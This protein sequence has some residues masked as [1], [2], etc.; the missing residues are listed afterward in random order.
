[1]WGRDVRVLRGVGRVRRRAY[2]RGYRTVGEGSTG[3]CCQCCPSAG[4]AEG[5]AT[6]TTQQAVLRV[7]PEKPSESSVSEFDSPYV[8][9]SRA[10]FDVYLEKKEELDGCFARVNAQIQ[11]L[12]DLSNKEQWSADAGQAIL[13]SFRRNC[14]LLTD[15][16][17]P[18]KK[19][20]IPDRSLVMKAAEL[21]M[22]VAW[23]NARDWPWWDKQYK[24]IDARNLQ[25]PGL[26]AIDWA[27]ELGPILKR[28]NTLG[29]GAA[30]QIDTHTRFTTFG[31][32]D[33]KPQ[34]IHWGPNWEPGCAQADLNATDKILDL[35]KLRILRLQ[36][37]PGLPFRGMEKLDLNWAQAI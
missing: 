25:M 33:C 7:V 17:N 12:I 26:Q 21:A 4:C 5:I 18:L 35:R 11:D 22:W 2:W 32:G 15:K 28:L 6:R 3:E 1:M 29:V 14:R 8:P 9:V 10:A 19:G 36:H 30:M 23:A 24:L 13:D 16:P 27:L 34:Q 31:P 20:D 37:I